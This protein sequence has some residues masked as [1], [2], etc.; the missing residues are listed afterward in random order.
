MLFNFTQLFFHFGEPWSV[1][2]KTSRHQ[3]NVAPKFRSFLSIRGLIWNIATTIKFLVKLFLVRCKQGVLMVISSLSSYCLIF[4]APADIFP[5]SIS[6]TWTFPT[7]L[8][9]YFLSILSRSFFSNSNVPLLLSFTVLTHFLYCAI[10]AWILLFHQGF[11]CFSLL[12]SFFIFLRF[13]ATTYAPAYSKLFIVV[14]EVCC[15]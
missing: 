11:F 13:S 5:F 7:S 8:T 1:F 2:V 12:L 14:I 10:F 15:C 9:L 6:I 4:L 3:P